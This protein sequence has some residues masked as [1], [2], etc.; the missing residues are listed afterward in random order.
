[1]DGRWSD[2][3]FD[4]YPLFRHRQPRGLGNQT[5]SS[6]GLR[7]SFLTYT[8]GKKY[9]T[10]W[11]IKNLTTTSVL[12]YTRGSH[13]QATPPK[14]VSNSKM[15]SPT[16]P[17]WSHGL[18][19]AASDGDT[20]RLRS[21]LQQG[22]SPDTTGGIVCWLRGASEF[23]KRTPLHYAAKGGHS[24]CIR[25]LLLYG[26]DPNC[27]DEDGYTPIHYVCQFYNPWARGPG[28][29]DEVCRCLR[30]LLDFGADYRTTTNSNYTPMELARRHKNSVC[31]N[32]L[33]KQGVYCHISRMLNV[34]MD[35]PYILVHL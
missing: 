21:L 13:N 8:P 32:E 28:K 24:S 31:V 29:A 16:L 17:A 5:C 35:V 25:L 11:G 23:Q 1:M 15:C 10:S 9:T 33:L 2:L 27:R 14:H 12:L 19:W 22:C 4:F 20:E 6:L 26:A 3:C 7:V 18:L 34:S 30:H